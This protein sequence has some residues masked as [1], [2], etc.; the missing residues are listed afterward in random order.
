MQNY[1]TMVDHLL[2]GLPYHHNKEEFDWI[3]FRLSQ[4]PTRSRNYVSY[5]RSVIECFRNI[6]EEHY[7]FFFLL[8]CRIV[9]KFIPLD[10][11][12]KLVHEDGFFTFLT[13]VNVILNMPYSNQFHED[14]MFLDKLKQAIAF[15]KKDKTNSLFVQELLSEAELCRVQYFERKKRFIQTI[16]EELIKKAWHP[17]RV[18]KYIE[19]GME[20]EDM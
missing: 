17:R 3:L 11:G 20:P 6:R 12:S 15:V 4:Y 16:Q 14:S 7:E 19:A 2:Q 13:T 9:L 5:A 18:L 1:S 8:W 10:D